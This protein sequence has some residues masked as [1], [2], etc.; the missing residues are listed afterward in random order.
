VSAGLL[1]LAMLAWVLMSAAVAG[2]IM[3]VSV[4]N[5]KTE[6]LRD[7]SYEPDDSDEWL[8]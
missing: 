2:L 4:I 7:W 6:E 8:A 1:M 5:E 3:L